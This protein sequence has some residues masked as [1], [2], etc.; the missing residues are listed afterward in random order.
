[1]SVAT[2][3]TDIQIGPY[4]IP[5]YKL[6]VSVVRTNKPPVIPVRGAGYPQGT[7]IIER[8]MDKIALTL[9]LDRLH[10]RSVNLIKKLEMP[11][12]TGL[13]NRAGV[14]VVYDSGDY[15]KCQDLAG[16]IF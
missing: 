14:D 4:K 16:R 1:M 7:F 12:I 15:Q 6:N 8:V 9:K 3:T 10:V 2:V 11:F 13:K 5:H